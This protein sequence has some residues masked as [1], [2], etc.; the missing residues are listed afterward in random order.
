MKGK[1]LLSLLLAVVLCVSVMGAFTTGASADGPATAELRVFQAITATNG[2]KPETAVPVTYTLT[3]APAQEGSVD[4]TTVTLSGNDM[5]VFNFA[6]T[7]A[8]LYTYRLESQATDREFY[9]F[10]KSWYTVEVHVR[11]QDDGT[12]IT[13]VIVKDKDGNKVE[14]GEVTK[15][16]AEDSTSVKAGDRYDV[17]YRHLYDLKIVPLVIDETGNNSVAAKVVSGDTPAAASNF[18]FTFR[19]VSMDAKNITAQPMPAAANGQNSLTVTR[20]G[21]GAVDIGALTFTEPGEY[22]YQ[23]SE[24]TGAAQGYTYDTRIYYVTY[25][26]SLSGANL[27]AVRTV[28]L[29]GAI[30]DRATFNNRYT[31][32]GVPVVPVR[33][34]TPPVTPRP[35]PVPTPAPTP[36][37]IVETTPAPTPTPEVI[38][39]EPV[40]Q[41][42]PERAW[43]LVNL[44]CTVLAVAD[45]GWM[46]GSFI[47]NRKGKEEDG[48]EE[49][50]KDHNNVKPF[51][52]IPAVGSIVAFL[53]TE[54]M[55]N[56]MI[57]VDK[58]TILMVALL[59]ANAGLT[60]WGKKKLRRC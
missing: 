32:P 53:L 28:S 33:P 38:V 4:K 18:S 44:I 37:P 9:T 14:G 27:S 46:V 26:V 19:T 24:N 55:K 3:P 13:A 41:A 42:A 54:N 29:N 45:C 16:E 35:T 10:D 25:T 40:P 59:A 21:A 11:N 12:L 51:T 43:A 20:T 34:I 15:E 22:V 5:G 2:H 30:V 52:A 49:L 7:H 23:I 17:A 47:K 6:Y 50:T 56:P 48:A 36:A 39:E 1:K 31:A 58:W 60:F 57:L 8:G